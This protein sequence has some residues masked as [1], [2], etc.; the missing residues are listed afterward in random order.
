M[1]ELLNSPPP[2]D[3]VKVPPSRR[4]QG[5]GGKR[6]PTSAP[7]PEKEDVGSWQSL[8]HFLKRRVTSMQGF[9]PRET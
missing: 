5:L 2:E 3:P 1:G 7:S 8:G 4:K 9:P 6:K